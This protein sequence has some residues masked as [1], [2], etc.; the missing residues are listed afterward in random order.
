M[1]KDSGKNKFSELRKKAQTF[2]ASNP[3]KA[4]EKADMDRADVRQLIHELDT[5]QIELELQNEDL[6]T[7]QQELEKS[8]HRYADFYDFAPVAFITA[9]DKG[10]I[11]EANLTAGDML[12]LARGQL[13]NHLLSDFIW[14]DDQD[15][16]YLRWRKLL[17][18]RRQQSY[19]LRLQRSVNDAYCRHFGV[20]HQDILGTN[21]LPAVHQDDLPL[22]KDRFKKPKKNC[23]KRMTSWSNG[24]PNV[25]LHY[26]NR[27]PNCSIPKN[28][29]PSATCPPPSPTSSTIPCRAS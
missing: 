14:P 6:R 1:E 19:D 11:I 20:K 21:F 15:V 10:L 5:Y 2:L 17:E 9:N 18:T 23:R 22:V 13:L 16:F 7:A 3:E 24:L 12:G 27:M 25:R 8:R 4:L 29:P 26:R 28:L